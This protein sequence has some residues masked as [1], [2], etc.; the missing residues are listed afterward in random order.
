MIRYKYLYERPVADVSS[1]ERFMDFESIL[2]DT[3]KKKRSQLIRNSV[4]L[5]ALISAIVFSV[6]YFSNNPRNNRISGKRSIPHIISDTISMIQKI[7][8]NPIQEPKSNNE[9]NA[10]QAIDNQQKT[11][12]LSA[13][14]KIGK[15]PSE[16]AAEDHYKLKENFTNDYVFIQ[17]EPVI[18]FD[19]L[20]AYFNWNL[21]YPE[22]LVKEK[23]EGKVIIE[24]VITREGKVGDVAVVQPLHP[25]L[26]SIAVV[27]VRQMP[28]WK[29]A[30]RNGQ[31][32]NSKH[33]IPLTFNIVSK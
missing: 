25:V 8:Q 7:E 2:S 30:S 14:N 13:K 33:S 5:T 24:F 15:H 16:K 9:T 19:S 21:N 1:T 32:I 23:I 12:N 26:D 18:G 31:T 6:F 20:H 3:L 29:P 27:C 28:E 22:E 10:D 17:A 11:G 4:L